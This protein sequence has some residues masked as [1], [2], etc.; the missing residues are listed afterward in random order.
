MALTKKTPDTIAA[1]LK[2]SASGVEN[3]LMLTYHNHKPDDY[4]A[5]AQNPEN[6]KVPEGLSDVDAVR[7]I[8]AGFVLFLVKSFDD[9]TAEDFPLTHEGLLQL[10]RHYPGVL[11][12]IVQGY[13]MARAA[14]VEKN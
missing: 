6:M 3:L 9:A 5:F 1:R 4:D 11:L 8:N 7:S 12:G 13:H 14:K 2:V 10:E